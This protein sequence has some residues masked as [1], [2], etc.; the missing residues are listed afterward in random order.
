MHTRADVIIQDL[1]THMGSAVGYGHILV[2]T[3]F[4]QIRG[5]YAIVMM[6][7][8]VGI[9]IHEIESRILSACRI[10]SGKLNNLLLYKYVF[11]FF[12]WDDV[13]P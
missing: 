5:I 2:L 13:L 12:L 9:D 11:S 4:W 6:S 7:E 10:R 3:V 8:T 1:P